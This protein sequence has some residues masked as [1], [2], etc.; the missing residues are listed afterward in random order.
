MEKYPIEIAPMGP[1]SLE[2]TWPER[3][4]ESILKDILSF[5]SH[6]R[7]TLLSND[8]D[9]ETVPAYNS[10]LLIRRNAKLDVA[11]WKVKLRKAYGEDRK[12]VVAKSTLW[13]LPVCYDNEF[14]LDL[15][16]TA[17]TLAL[18]QRN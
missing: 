13:H 15:A 3:V 9:W 17:K 11:A 14:G 10:L 2:I 5:E 4:E 12:M 6:I 7:D 16:S 8:D 18:H 1:Y